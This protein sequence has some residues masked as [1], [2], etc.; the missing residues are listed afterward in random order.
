MTGRISFG[1]NFSGGYILNKRKIGLAMSLV[2][3][4]GTIL[5]ACGNSE[6]ATAQAKAKTNSVWRWL[7]T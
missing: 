5:G 2:I 7:L 3:A 6:K 1:P 4:A